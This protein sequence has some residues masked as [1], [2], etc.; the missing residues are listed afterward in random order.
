MENQLEGL[1]STQ[2]EVDSDQLRFLGNRPPITPLS[3]NFALSE[4]LVSMLT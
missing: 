2:G 3:H 1:L 4:K